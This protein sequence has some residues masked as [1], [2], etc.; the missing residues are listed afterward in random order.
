MSRNQIIAGI[1]VGLGILLARFIAPYIG[2]Y[3]KDFNSNSVTRQQAGIYLS[4]SEREEVLFTSFIK[5]YDDF[6]S[7]FN[8]NGVYRHS[9]IFQDE[10][11]QKYFVF[12]VFDLD[13]SFSTFEIENIK[14]KKINVF[15]NKEELNDL[16]YGTRDKP[17]PI[18]I[19]S[20]DIF[21][22]VDPKEIN[23]FKSYN[24]F[25]MLSVGKYLKYF[26][27]KEDFKKM[28]PENKK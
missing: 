1:C 20:D 12:Q 7:A 9:Y 10:N 26:K 11:S 18:F 28:F 23:S 24:N 19:F 5:K 22:S 14:N 4:N 3:F 21:N 2:A 6:S 27:S 25:K 16:N 8:S 17:I 13:I 15:V